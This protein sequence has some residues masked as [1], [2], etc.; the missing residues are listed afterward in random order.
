M[1]PPL[2][3]VSDL[4]AGY[5]EMDV[6]DG[7]SIEVGEGEIVAVVGRNGA[8]KTTLLRCILGSIRPHAGTIEFRGE[9]LPEEVIE[10]V[11]AGVTLVPEDRRI[12]PGL[13]VQEN[14]ELARLG[15]SEEGYR[16]SIERVFETFENLAAGRH[17]KGGNLSGGEQQMLAMGRA[18][19]AGPRLLLL[20]EPTEGLAP[21]IVDRIEDIIAELNDEGIAI[22]LVEQNLGV[23]LRLAD[24]I[25][26]LDQGRIV[27][28]GTPAELEEREDVID[29]YL[30]VHVR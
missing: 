22:L 24:R 10:T 30:G 27:Y 18:L 7:V 17:R 25:Y 2:L 4:D 29:R 20:D 12:L 15:G 11:R 16:W 5:T 8:G 9:P 6:L 3:S 19:V 23:A 1:T 14:L 26:V 21:A 28:E 13:T